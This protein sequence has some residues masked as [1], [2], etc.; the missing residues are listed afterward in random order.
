MEALIVIL[1]VSLWATYC[2]FVVWIMELI[3]ENEPDDLRGIYF[4]CLE[5]QDS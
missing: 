2:Y 3:A 5:I 4:N 1:V